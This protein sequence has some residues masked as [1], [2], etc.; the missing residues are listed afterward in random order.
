MQFLFVVLALV[1][2][3]STA[4]VMLGEPRQESGPDTRPV[5]ARNSP[6]AATPDE[7]MFSPAPP[8]RRPLPTVYRPTGTAA[9]ASATRGPGG[10]FVFEAEI[11]GV[12]APMMFDTGASNVVL[13]GE[14]AARFG[15]NAA[16]LR[17]SIRINTVN[18]AASAAPT[19][20]A[21][22]KVGTIT[23][24]NVPAVVTKPGKLAINLL[25]QSF[26]ATMTGFTTEGNRL[27][28]RGN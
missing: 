2:L 5:I 7:T 20:I 24:T 4:R 19:T 23:R 15:I 13:R 26:V 12:L 16:S 18:G 9:T 11:N 28:L 14:D 25:G 21:E 1:L 10:H 6:A 22:L 8:A 17:Y 27:V 3:A